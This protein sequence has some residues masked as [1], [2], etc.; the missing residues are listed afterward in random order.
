MLSFLDA[1]AYLIDLMHDKNPEI[2]KLCATTL[3]IIGE[4]DEEWAKKIK[5]EKFRWHNSQ[6]L[7]L[8]SFACF[9]IHIS[10]LLPILIS[11]PSPQSREI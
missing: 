1:P 2:R 5:M 8:I 10:A 6:V 3:D 9:N 7:N 11:S 4:I